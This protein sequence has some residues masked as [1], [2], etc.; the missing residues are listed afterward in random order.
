[1][2]ESESKPNPEQT[3]PNTISQELKRALAARRALDKS[4]ELRSGQ[5]R[6]PHPVA[7]ASGPGEVSPG[8]S[9]MLVTASE[10]F[11][12]SLQTI[13]GFLELLLEG[14]VPDAR[15]AR[16]FLGIAYRESQYLSNRVKDLQ[17]AASAAAGKLRLKPA[18][19]PMEAVLRS[20]LNSF[21]DIATAKGLRLGSM[22]PEELPS[23]QGDEALLRQAL[24]GLLD[25]VIRRTEREGELVVNGTSDGAT[26]KLRFA[27]FNTGE[28][29]A[30]GQGAS[31][32]ATDD[33]GAMGLAFYVADQIIRQHDGTL[34]AHGPADKAR[35][36]SI[37]LP[38]KPKL[39]KR[40][41]LLIVDD[42]PHAALL[43]E[44]SVEKEGF[45]A[46]IAVNGLDAL[47]KAKSHQIDLVILDVLLPGMDGFEVCHRLR[48][49][50]ETASLPIV[51][52]SAKAR[53]E[54][55]AT[56]LRLGADAYLAKPL[57]MSQ[58]MSTI[59]TLLEEGHEK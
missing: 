56:A 53:D 7:I 43:V 21:N 16:Q 29:H 46:I 37:S 27:G 57:A 20:M 18:P 6:K 26:L 31:A 32:E 11:R 19:V 47:E 59:E 8:E 39:P 10:E 38:L 45:E 54:D 12:D 28:S 33:V 24:T 49:A 25:L 36:F 13:Q 30:A 23:I 52:V 14:K 44:Y 2:S 34:V 40:G 3:D 55:R 50:P 58:L 41:K 51:M 48:S 5:P 1:M 9:K 4:T 17:T 42:N 15:Q 22:P 35:S